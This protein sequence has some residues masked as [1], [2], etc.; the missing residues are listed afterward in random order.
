MSKISINES[1]NVYGRLTVISH[2]GHSRNGEYVWLCQCECGKRSI[3]TGGN[4][5]GGWANSCGCLKKELLSERATGNT[6][7]RLKKGRGAFNSY[8]GTQKSNAKRR[9]YVW[10][11]TEDQVL[12]LNKQNCHYCG[13]SPEQ[14]LT[15]EGGYGNYIYNG[16]D[17]MHNTE[18]YTP[19]NVVPCCKYCNRAKSDMDYHE[20]IQLC[21]NIA[22][23]HEE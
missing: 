19:E 8:Y 23:L 21:R 1:G 20:F 15:R 6:Y 18:G 5:R 22:Q 4:L 12:Y 7:N 14:I 16:L 13:R 9:G 10:E 2:E 17:R 11:L 3:H